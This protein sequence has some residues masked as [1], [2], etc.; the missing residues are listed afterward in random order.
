MQEIDHKLIS[1]IC[2]TRYQNHHSFL[3]ALYVADNFRGKRYVG[4]AVEGALSACDPSYTIGTDTGSELKHMSEVLGF[5]KFWDTYVAKFSLEKITEKLA[6]VT[7]PNDHILRPIHEVQTDKL[8]EYD[9]L[10]FGTDR[11]VFLE[12]W[13][14][15]PG[16]FGW[17]VLNAKTK[18]IAGYAVV[19]LAIRGGG[20][21]TGMA[22]APLYSDNV[23]IAKCLLKTAADYCLANKAVPKSE[24]EMVHPVGDNCGESAPSL[25]KELEA[26]LIHIAHRMYSKGIPAG[27]QTKKIYGIASPTFG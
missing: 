13:I 7:P 22:I 27:R 16:S 2:A 14:N 21:G 25:M 4:H 24:L 5:K 3:G 17:A 1:H 19:K 20:T 8:F 9:R 10:V 6:A 12:R 26:E 15:A 18:K 23:L 11:Q